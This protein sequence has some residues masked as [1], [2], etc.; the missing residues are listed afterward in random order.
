MQLNWEAILAIT[1][2][3]AVIAAWL[4]REVRNVV[5]DL[6]SEFRV[7]IAEKYVPREVYQVELDETKRRLTQ[8]EYRPH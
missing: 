3:V 2:A 5:K 1:S 4:G 6:M 8:L 7:E